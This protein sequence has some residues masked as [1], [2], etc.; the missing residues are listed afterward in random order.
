M[1]LIEELQKL[2]K[3]DVQLRALRSRLD[4]AQRYL[5]V[6]TGELEKLTSR[7]AELQQRR[8]QFQANIANLETETK[9][10]DERLE[11]LRGDL[12]SAVNNKQYTTVLSE[13]NTAKEQRSQIEDKTIAEM[14][15]I[16]KLDA[17]L[18]ELDAKIAERSKVRDV[19][20][21]Q[22]QQ[23]QADV[24]ERLAELETERAAAAEHIPSKEMDIF[25]NLAEM[26]EGEAMAPVE[27]ISRR[28]REYS[29][30]VC[31]MQIPFEQVSALM[32]NLD[33]VVCCASCHRILYMAEETKGAL[34]G[35]K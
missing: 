8:K 24:G 2:Y 18:E 12:N 7:K 15:N 29:C 10:I 23:R 13:L 25:D 27:E 20:S 35:K 4:S 1:T 28:N 26:Y 19:A 31:N 14:E 5:N 16:E 17:E 22:L 32:N 33:T 30:G 34:A 6:Q 21:A 11:K 3:V 9:S